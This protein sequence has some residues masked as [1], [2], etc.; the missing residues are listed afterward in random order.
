MP[1]SK[2]A[3][4]RYVYIHQ[5][6]TKR[7]RTLTQLLNG[8]NNNRDEPISK[9][10][11]REAIHDLIDG[12]VFGVR[13][14]IEQDSRYRYHYTEAFELFHAYKLEDEEVLALHMVRDLLAFQSSNPLFAQFGHSV[15]KLEEG[16]GL[17]ITNTPMTIPK[18][19]IQ[20]DDPP[21]Y[22]GA[23]N[24]PTILMA[25]LQRRCLEFIYLKYDTMEYRSRKVRPLM[26]KEYRGRWYV[27]VEEHDIV[28]ERKNFAIDRISDL[29]LLDEHFDYPSDFDPNSRYKDVIGIR[30]GDVD[31]LC[32][33][34]W[35]S[36]SQI[37]Y[38]DSLNLHASQRVVER[39]DNGFVIELTIVPNYE[40]EAILLGYGADVKVLSPDSLALRHQELLRKA[41]AVYQRP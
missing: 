3:L 28:G 11:M 22:Q 33:R 6:L 18:S 5:Q 14:P 27:V 15:E 32:I 40:F 1:K 30:I 37:G 10:S 29:G 24:L 2:N 8:Y 41:L 26:L 34:L 35:F 7:A 38:L 25:I 12:T 39:L 4:S 19:V 21:Q 9:T 16:M 17:E 36:K 13:A 31:P 20:T 23:E